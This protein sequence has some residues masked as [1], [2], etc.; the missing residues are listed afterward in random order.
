MLIGIIMLIL[1]VGYFLSEVG[2]KPK[3]QKA[4]ENRQNSSLILKYPLVFV[5]NS[6]NAQLPEESYNENKGK[7]EA[8]FL[9]YLHKYFPKKVQIDLAVRIKSAYYYPDFTLIFPEYDLFV[10]IEIDEPYNY[11]GKPTHTIGSDDTRNNFFVQAGWVVIRFT[12][13]QVMRQPSQCCKFIAATVAQIA[14]E[15]QIK[16]AFEKIPSLSLLPS[17]W[18]EQQAREMHASNTRRSY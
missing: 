5:G 15:P 2:S 17:T 8:Y 1:I 12:E 6:T 3:P 16:I 10:D 9:T 11:K 7:S 18:S 13:E 4:V 14:Q